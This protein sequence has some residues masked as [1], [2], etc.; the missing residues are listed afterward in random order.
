ML[1]LGGGAGFTLVGGAGICIA[2]LGTDACVGAGAG[3]C[4]TLG[5]DAGVR[6]CVCRVHGGLVDVDGVLNI[7]QRLLTAR[8]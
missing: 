7:A 1:T 2:T 6:T 4:N 5:V 8:S 3:D